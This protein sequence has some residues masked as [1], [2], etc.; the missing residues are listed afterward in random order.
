MSGLVSVVLCSAL[1]SCGLA[2]GSH[3]SPDGGALS[4]LSWSSSL[5]VVAVSLCAL[6]CL[7]FLMLACLCC[8]KRTKGF[9]VRPLTKHMR[10]TGAP[11]CPRVVVEEMD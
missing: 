9:K 1:V 5:T 7:V 3:F 11:R 8:K 4:D 6:F 2:L 10:T